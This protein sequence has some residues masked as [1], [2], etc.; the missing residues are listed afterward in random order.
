MTKSEELLDLIEGKSP[1]NVSDTFKIL[2]K[3][4]DKSGIDD[5]DLTDIADDMG[6][7]DLNDLDRKDLLGEI[8]DFIWNGI[9]NKNWTIESWIEDVFGDIVGKNKIKG[10]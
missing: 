7:G 3:V 10:L 5:S 6:V 9:K 2:L 8:A 1:K 4:A